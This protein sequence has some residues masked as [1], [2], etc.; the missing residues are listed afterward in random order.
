VHA[1]VQERSFP[2]LLADGDF[3]AEQVE[4]CRRFVRSALAEAGVVAE[5]AEKSPAGRTFEVTAGCSGA[6]DNLLLVST[7]S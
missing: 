7:V 5:I 2:G 4:D 6:E 3:S 1:A